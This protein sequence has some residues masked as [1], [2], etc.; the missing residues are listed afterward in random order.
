M[1]SLRRIERLVSLQSRPEVLG[2]AVYQVRNDACRNDADPARK[3]TQVQ[4][5]KDYEGVQMKSS[6]E[7]FEEEMSDKYE[8]FS[9]AIACAYFCG[10][11]DD[12]YYVGGDYIYHG[13]SCSEA[14]FWLWRGWQASRAAIEIELPEIVWDITECGSQHYDSDDVKGSI[15]AAGLTVKGES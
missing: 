4:V 12:G 11:D 7:Q 13:T 9:D 2:Q 14:L 15:R 8:W 6:R 10:E 3:R 1:L 5:Q